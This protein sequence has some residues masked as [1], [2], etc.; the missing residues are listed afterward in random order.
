[1]HYV[2][3]LAH[4]IAAHEILLPLSGMRTS[5]SHSIDPSVPSR[6]IGWQAELECLLWLDAAFFYC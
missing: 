2:V 5:F 3:P 4:V 6:P 1:M